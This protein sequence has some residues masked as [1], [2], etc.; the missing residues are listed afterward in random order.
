[1][2]TQKWTEGDQ[3][4]FLSERMTDYHEHK[5]RHTL[6]LF[7]S[8]IGKDWLERYPIETAKFLRTKVDLSTGT[9]EEIR[10]QLITLQ[11]QV[12]ATSLFCT[13]EKNH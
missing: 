10:S 9:P 6:V 12:T 8:K 5:D 3:E 11:L 13:R 1:M 2:V 7:W 4:E